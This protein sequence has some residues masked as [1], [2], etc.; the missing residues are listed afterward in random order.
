M[1]N[2]AK[3][4]L[5]STLIA[6]SLLPP[7]APT[8]AQTPPLR[9]QIIG[10]WGFVVTSGTRK[11]GT[12]FDIF[13]PTPNGV[14]MFH[15]DGHFVLINTRPGRPNYAGSN[16]NEGTP[17]EFKTTVQGSIAYFG[18]FTVDEAKKAFVLRIQGSTFPNYEA[19]EQVRPFTIEGDEMR[20]INP[21]PAL[22][23]PPLDLVLKR[24]A[25]TK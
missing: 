16:R 8:W 18:S 12:K 5:T 13:G 22:G 2:L 1:R 23:G 11:D 21:N 4:L 17:E 14:L 6:A 19:T 9:E 7:T 20:S 24:L 25:P 10:T 3:H 15:P